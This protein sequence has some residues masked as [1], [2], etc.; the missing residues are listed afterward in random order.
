MNNQE[1]VDNLRIIIIDD[2]GKLSSAKLNWSK[3]EVIV[4][5]KWD[6]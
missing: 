5:G 3:S 1:E 4:C 2:F 6:G